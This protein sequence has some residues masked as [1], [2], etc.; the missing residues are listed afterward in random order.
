MVS[1]TDEMKRSSIGIL[2]SNSCSIRPMMSFRSKV[3]SNDAQLSSAILQLLYLSK[4]TIDG[5]RVIVLNFGEKMSVF[6]W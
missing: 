6:Q 1:I 4:A 3:T 2:E 5:I